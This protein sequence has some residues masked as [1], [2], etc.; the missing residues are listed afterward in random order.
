M[1]LLATLR[2]HS[3]PPGQS[4]CL[5]ACKTSYFFSVPH[6][7][8]P[9]TNVDVTAASC[10]YVLYHLLQKQP[11][12]NLKYN[13]NVPGKTQIRSESALVTHTHIGELWTV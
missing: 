9:N 13:A 6:I 12:L 2:A 10:Q 8:F 5:S 7:T 1:K 11:N 3:Q 4:F